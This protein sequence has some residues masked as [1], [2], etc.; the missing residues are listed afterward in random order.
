MYGT[1]SYLQTSYLLRRSPHLVLDFPLNGPMYY[2]R[3]SSIIGSVLLRLD[4]KKGT[5]EDNYVRDNRD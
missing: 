1:L 4:L 5:T 3:L 2:L